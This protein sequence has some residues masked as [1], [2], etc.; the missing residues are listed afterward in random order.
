MIKVCAVFCSLKNVSALKF[1]PRKVLYV[2]L[3]GFL[4][5][6]LTQLTQHYTQSMCH[7]ADTQTTSIA[8]YGESIGK[9]NWYFNLYFMCMP[10]NA[11]F[12]IFSFFFLYAQLRKWK[13]LI[14]NMRTWVT[15]G[16][17]GFLSNQNWLLIEK[18]LKHRCKQKWTQ[19]Y[20]YIFDMMICA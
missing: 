11:Q 19:R 2:C 6:L 20:I 5:S 10:C 15:A 18:I 9:R 7:D 17:N 3:A 8:S 13:W 1:Y 12:L 14:R 16:K 4:I